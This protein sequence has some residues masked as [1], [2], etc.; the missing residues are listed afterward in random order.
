MCWQCES[1]Y[2]DDD[3]EYEA[4]EETVSGPFDGMQ[5]R[6]DPVSDWEDVKPG[7]TEFSVYG[8]IEFRKKPEV[9]ATF[10]YDSNSAVFYT[11]E[12]IKKAVERNIQN[13]HKFTLEVT[14]K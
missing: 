2:L 6:T 4:E 12:G 7:Q 3:Y 8:K 1:P 13:G 9:I 14:Y 10:R 5:Y 11:V